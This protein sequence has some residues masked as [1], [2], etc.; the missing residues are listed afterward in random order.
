MKAL[1]KSRAQLKQKHIGIPGEKY[2]AWFYETIV[3]LRELL[4]EN[5]TIYVHLDWHIGH[6]AKVILDEVFGQDN[7]RVDIVW[8]RVAFRHDSGHFGQVSD[9]IFVYSKGPNFIYSKQYVPYDNEYIKS[10]YTSQDEGG[11]FTTHNLS[12]AGQGPSRKFGDREIAPP[13]GTHWRFSQ[14]NID[15]LMAEG[16]IVFTSTGKPRYK[17]YAHEMPGKVIRFNLD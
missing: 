9:A 10:H 7:L 14:E 5:G 13:P 8:K 1:P 3:L 6:Y 17:M 2:F 4:T 12:A 15:R 16:K 11:K